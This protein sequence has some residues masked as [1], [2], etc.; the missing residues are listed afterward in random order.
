MN[1][2]AIANV[3]LFFMVISFRK[4]HSCDLSKAYLPIDSTCKSYYVCDGDQLKVE[5]CPDDQKWDSSFFT[6]VPSNIVLPGCF[7]EIPT[8]APK[9]NKSSIRL[10]SFNLVNFSLVLFLLISM[11]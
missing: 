10:Y 5:V 2:K 3:L 8:L 11:F 1:S 4:T 6:C 7:S 9:T